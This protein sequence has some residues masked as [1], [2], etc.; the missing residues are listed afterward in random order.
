MKSFFMKLLMWTTRWVGVWFLR[1]VALTITG[2]YFLFRPNRVRASMELYCGVFPGRTRLFYRYCA[3]RQF[4]DFSAS[5]CDRL[6]LEA[7]AKVRQ[8]T[9][10]WEY[11]EAAARAG[12]GGIFLTSHLGNWEVG[13]RLFKRK[14]MKMLLLMG[15]RDPRQVARFQKEDMKSEGLEVLVSSPENRTPFAGLEALEFM[16][17]GG[18]VAVA[19]DLVWADQRR[20]VKVNLLGHEVMLPAAPH[21]LALLSAAPLF[22]LFTFRTGRAAHHFVI[23]EPRMVKALSRTDRNAAVQQSAQ[24]YARELEKAVRRH[25]WQWHIFEPFLGP[26]VEEVSPKPQP[27]TE[28]IS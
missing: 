18:F 5:Y 8:T 1:C 7:G 23:S 17:D 6:S 14:G 21:L 3:W 12:T 4:T 16:E 2:G 10:G 25:P 9:E 28:S 13:A 15:E 19:G 27:S 20:R 26:A 24:E 22:T 11:V